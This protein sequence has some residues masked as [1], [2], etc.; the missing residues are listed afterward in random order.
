MGD[1]IAFHKTPEVERLINELQAYQPPTLSPVA[2]RRRGWRAESIIEAATRGEYDT[3]FTITVDGK[4]Y[5]YTPAKGSSSA[6][7]IR[8]AEAVQPTPENILA[9]PIAATNAHF[10]TGGYDDGTRRSISSKLDAFMASPEAWGE[11]F[12]SF[13]EQMYR[14]GAWSQANDGSPASLRY[15]GVLSA[16]SNTFGAPPRGEVQFRRGPSPLTSGPGGSLAGFKGEMSDD[17]LALVGQI[18]GEFRSHLD[19]MGLGHVRLD[20]SDYIVAREGGY[21]PAYGMFRPD[22]DEIDL[23]VLY[24][25]DR[26][27][28]EVLESVGDDLFNLP[29]GQLESLLNGPEGDA[30]IK[31][32]LYQTLNHEAL[33]ALRAANVVTDREWKL[34]VTEARKRGYGDWAIDSYGPNVETGKQV[35]PQEDAFE[36]NT[37]GFRQY[38]EEAVA[39]MFGDY[40]LDAKAFTPAT[41]TVFEKI[42]QFFAG[43]VKAVLRQPNGVDV[44]KKMLSGEVGARTPYTSPVNPY[45]GNTR[46]YQRGKKTALSKMDLSAITEEDPRAYGAPMAEGEKALALDPFTYKGKMMPAL[47]VYRDVTRDMDRLAELAAKKAASP[48][49][50]FADQKE[51]TALSKQFSADNPNVDW[52][53]IGKTEIDPLAR[54]HARRLWEASKYPTGVAPKKPGALSGPLGLIDDW[55]AANRKLRLAS[56]ASAPQQSVRQIFGNIATFLIDAPEGVV[57]MFKPKAYAS[58]YKSLKTADGHS[59]YGNLLLAR[60]RA[61]PQRLDTRKKSMAGY[62]TNINNPTIKKI[63][64]IFAPKRIADLV[65]VGDGVATEGQHFTHYV[66]PMKEELRAAP[67]MGAKV[68]NAYNGKYKG[69]FPAITER[70]VQDVVAK[71]IKSRKFSGEPMSRATGDDIKDDLIAAFKDKPMGASGPKALRDFAD[72]VG[73]NVNEADNLHFQNATR[74]VNKTFQSWENLNIDQAL[75]HV[76]LFT[77]WASRTSGTYAKAMLRKPWMAASLMRLTEEVQQEAEAGNYPEWM[78]GYTRILNSPFGLTLFA[79][80][81]DAVSTMFVMAEWQYGESWQEAMKGDLTALGSL[82]GVLP[83]VI[84]APIDYAMWLA[85]AYG[86]EDARMPYNITGLTPITRRVAQG[87]N[88]AGEAGLLP[89][90]MGSDANGVFHPLNETPLEDVAAH[91]GAFLGR[92]VAEAHASEQI[93]QEQ[94]LQQILIEEHPEWATDPG[95]ADALNAAV[96]QMKND[97][98]AGTYSPEW[99]QSEHLMAGDSLNGPDFPGLPEPL[100]SLVGGTV[101][102]LSPIRIM[103]EPEIKTQ[104]RAGEVPVG[105]NDE[106]DAGNVKN[107][108][109]DTLEIAN[110]KAQ[111]EDYWAIGTDTGMKD[112]SR[113]Y[114]SITNANFDGTITIYGKTYTKEALVD[115]VMTKSQRYD[116][117]NDYLASQGYTSSDLDAYYAAREEMEAAHPD[118]AA[119][120]EFTSYTEDYEGGP[121][122]FVDAAVLSSPSYARYMAQLPYPPGSPEYYAAGDSADAF[123]ALEGRRSGIYDPTTLPDKGTIPNQPPGMT[124]SMKRA[125]EANADAAASSSGGDGSSYDDFVGDVQGNVD[126]IYNAQQ[127][128]D[129]WFPGA[130]YVAGVTYFDKGTYNALK[131]AGYNAPA[132]GDIAYE[133]YDWLLGN[134]TTTDPSVK[135]FLDQRE[136]AGTD[137]PATAKQEN[138][139]P[140][141]ILAQRG[142]NVDVVDTSVPRSDGAIDTSQMQRATP[143]QTIPGSG[144]IYSQ[145][146]LDQQTPLVVPPGRLVHVIEQHGDWAYVVAPGNQIGWM[147]TVHL[148]HA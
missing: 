114:Q 70:Q 11:K 135:A 122:A 115:G 84:S 119:Y 136:K 45:T 125:L 33:H 8:G 105:T 81:M 130:G 90:G 77:Y 106:Y 113:V 85:G 29:E 83:A 143:N 19:A 98:A 126:D 35:Y 28:T 71:A 20:I 51:L 18:A 15:D 138:V 40:A 117:A 9:D 69:D 79:N 59:D 25:T 97:A 133:Y 53:T 96:L 24:T 111:N 1:R 66:L 146:S 74:K 142:G 67:K 16:W 78:K 104:L 141:M 41:R 4:P 54:E 52:A 129:S 76:L 120:H 14:N 2:K 34:L 73:R 44:L 144:V 102:A 112:A 99:I 82:R 108:V 68:M 123:Y 86:G 139:S 87:L 58:V 26:V 56:L 23:A 38:E 91:I 127:L 22:A 64:D 65:Q 107:S 145:P 103:S 93:R 116:V 39:E 110:L 140:E 147:P 132:K 109:Y 94:H 31:R 89:A 134:A 121:E 46:Y 42:T 17:E 75:N 92:P 12:K 50:R 57:T 62:E 43:L 13:R 6:V 118:L 7:P 5:T 63:T 124:F 128:L 95:G 72:R 101:R 30:L 36:A 80:W 61:V 100:R 55:T 32:A 10:A 137:A 88:L 148:S 27:A 49:A 60:K 21:A 3:P 131:G 37:T 47:D 48:G